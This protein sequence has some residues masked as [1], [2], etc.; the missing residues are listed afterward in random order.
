MSVDPLGLLP[1]DVSSREARS[2][3]TLKYSRPMVVPFMNLVYGANAVRKDD[4]SG[5]HNVSKPR[6]SK[7]AAIFYHSVV[8]EWQI[9]LWD[10]NTS[11]EYS[12]FICL[13]S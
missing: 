7:S 11:G 4:Q 10:C 5:L 3:Q 2:A 12:R 1:F 6:T 13:Q 9:E 8:E